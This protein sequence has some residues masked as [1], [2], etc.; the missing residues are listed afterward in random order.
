[1]SHPISSEREKGQLFSVKKEARI[2]TKRNSVLITTRG[3]KGSYYKRERAKDRMITCHDQK[4]GA[5]RLE[6]QKGSCALSLLVRK[7]RRGEG[8]SSL[9]ERIEEEVLK[10]KKG[11]T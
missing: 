11:P 6:R 7:R 9:R 1:V 8:T 3:E 2:D 10:K 5:R 4:G